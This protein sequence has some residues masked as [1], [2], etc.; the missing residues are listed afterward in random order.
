MIDRD[1][2]KRMDFDYRCSDV[3]PMLEDELHL[4]GT[5]RL[6][7]DLKYC[8]DEVTKGNQ[9]VDFSKYESSINLISTKM[10]VELEESIL[11]SVQNV[12]NSVDKEELI[13]AIQYN[14]EQYSKGFKIGYSKAVDDALNAFKELYIFTSDEEKRID[15]VAERL[16]VGEESG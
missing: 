15:D 8:V 1:F 7:R 9:L 4:F 14:R 13:R 5:A 16:K 2:V 10:Q 12:E 3:I 11:K 6:I